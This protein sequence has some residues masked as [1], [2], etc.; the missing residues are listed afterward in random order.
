MTRMEDPPHHFWVRRQFVPDYRSRELIKVL[1]RTWALSKEYGLLFP[2][3]EQRV[4]NSYLQPQ[5]T[6]LDIS[7][8]LLEERQ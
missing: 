6:A 4:D 1:S 5:S 8:L 7:L 3:A 2:W